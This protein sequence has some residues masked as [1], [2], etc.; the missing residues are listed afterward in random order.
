MIHSEAE[1]ATEECPEP[2]K[3]LNE[4]LYAQIQYAWTQALTTTTPPFQGDMENPTYLKI[5]QCLRDFKAENYP[6]PAE[7]EVKP[8][9]S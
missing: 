7:E 2:A 4:E 8:L 9:E 3:V 1:P 5:V 6:V